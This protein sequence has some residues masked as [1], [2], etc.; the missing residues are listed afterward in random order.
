MSSQYKVTVVIPFF[1]SEAFIHRCVDS[2]INQSLK[3]IQVICIDDGSNDRSADIVRSLSTNDNRILLLSQ[4][5]GGAGKARNLALEHIEGEYVLFLDSDDY[6]SSQAL[7]SAYSLASERDSEIVVMKSLVFEDGKEE[8]KWPQN[9]CIRYD[10]LPK[11]ETFQLKEINKDIFSSFIW[12]PWDKLIKTELIQKKS[13][14]FQETRTTNDLLFVFSAMYLASSISITKEFLVYHRI[15]S[16][17]LSVT[18]EK[19]WTNFI[20]ALLAVKDFLSRERVYNVR[21]QDFL[22]YVMSFTVWQ[23][24][25]LPF[26]SMVK[27]KYLYLPLI[28][29]FFGLCHKPQSYYYNQDKLE[30]FSIISGERTSPIFI[31]KTFL[32][33]KNNIKKLLKVFK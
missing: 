21:E 31:C 9:N 6:L 12:W 15:S 14:Y 5:N 3:E 2:V 29:I 16:N 22:N 27:V 19:S 23:F 10:L 13:L 11:K 17:S 18:R 1:N 28:N 7:L 4:T 32:K 8:K 26:K 30:I 25:S 20:Q 33:N 24:C